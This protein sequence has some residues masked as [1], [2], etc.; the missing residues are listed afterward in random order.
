M[1]D[2][3]GEKKAGKVKQTFQ[4]DPHDPT[5]LLWCGAVVYPS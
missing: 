4:D 5:L 1:V 3:E 2:E